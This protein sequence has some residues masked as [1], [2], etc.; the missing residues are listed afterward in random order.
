MSEEKHKLPAIQDLYGDIEMKVKYNDLNAFLNQPPADEWL[1]VHPVIKVESGELNE[2][3]YPV[4]VPLKYVPIE[5]V[6]WL[7]TRI[8]IRWRREILDY[9]LIANSL[10]VKV[11]LHYQLPISLEWDYEDGIGA[12]PIQTQKGAGADRAG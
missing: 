4:L 10:V 7:L 11:R 1:K 12:V 5:R 3:G 6:E 8:F 2:K 9:K